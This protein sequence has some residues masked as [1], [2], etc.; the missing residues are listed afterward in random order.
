[1]ARTTLR[2]MNSPAATMSTEPGSAS[3]GQKIPF[4]RNKRVYYPQNVGFIAPNSPTDVPD[5]TSK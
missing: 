2:S 1:M 3:L 4:V 5:T